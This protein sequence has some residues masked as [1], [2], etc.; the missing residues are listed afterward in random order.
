[1]QKG[2]M[3]ILDVE[4]TLLYS[5]GLARG[6][7]TDFRPAYRYWD[8]PI[9]VVAMPIHTSFQARQHTKRRPKCVPKRVP[10]TFCHPACKTEHVKLSQFILTCTY[11]TL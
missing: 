2:S 4:H 3:L 5:M 9:N 10:S 8:L 1:M 6:S 11:S 7:C